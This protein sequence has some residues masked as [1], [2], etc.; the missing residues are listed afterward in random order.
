MTRLQKES[1]SSMSIRLK[2]I[3]QLE[4]RIARDEARMDAVSTLLIERN[5]LE[6]S[7]ETDE[8]IQEWHNLNA[9]IEQGKSKLAQLKAP[10]ELTKDDKKRI[11]KKNGTDERY[12]ITY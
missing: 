10:S 11:P 2:D 4:E 1:G 6:H 7:K 3:S 12:N 8:L 9:R 5:L